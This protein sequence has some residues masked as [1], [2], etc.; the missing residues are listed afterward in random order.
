[1]CKTDLINDTLCLSCQEK[2]DNNQITQFDI[3]LAKDLLEFEKEFPSLKKASFYRAIDVGDI[4]F[5]IIGGG[6]TKLYPPELIEKIKDLYEIPKII[7]IEKSDQKTMINEMIK[8]NV[9]IG[10]NKVFLPTGEEEYKILIS[11]PEGEIRKKG[12]LGKNEISLDLLK[13]ACTILLNS[14]VRIDFQ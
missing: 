13:Q 11:D 14:S 8:P 5:L 12:K 1:M 3:D 10:I 4:V 2:L 7:L 6:Q 9:L